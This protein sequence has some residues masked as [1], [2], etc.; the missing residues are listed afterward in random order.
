MKKKQSN[1]KVRIIFIGNNIWNCSLYCINVRFIGLPSLI[2]G[3]SSSE[4]DT[5]DI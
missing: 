3:N 2:E 5:L 4:T 1:L